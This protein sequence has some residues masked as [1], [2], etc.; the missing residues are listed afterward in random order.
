MYF[1]NKFRSDIHIL[2]HTT[3]ANAY[4]PLNLRLHTLEEIS[5][6]QF[7]VVVDTP[8]LKNSDQVGGFEPINPFEKV[9]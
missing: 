6:A 5:K 9:Y 2:S 7:I 1:P 4:L 3:V 8:Y